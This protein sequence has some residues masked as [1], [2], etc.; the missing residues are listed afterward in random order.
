MKEHI[1]EIVIGVSGIATTAAAWFLGGRQ[2]AQERH[3]KKHPKL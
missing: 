3:D 1:T 2:K